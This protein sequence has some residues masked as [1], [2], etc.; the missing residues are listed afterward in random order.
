[1]AKNSIYTAS[2]IKASTIDEKSLQYL[3][4]LAGSNNIKKEMNK[5]EEKNS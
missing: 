1:M 5:E 2:V 4:Y 3:N